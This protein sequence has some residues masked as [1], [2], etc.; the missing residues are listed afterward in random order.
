M[1][2]IVVVRMVGAT[3][4][5]KTNKN[6]IIFCFCFWICAFFRVQLEDPHS[7][8][9]RIKLKANSIELPAN[10]GSSKDTDIP[11][12]PV[13]ERSATPID[14]KPQENCYFC[15][16]GKL[17]T[18]NERGELV[19]ESGSVPAEPEN[20]KSV[21]C[22]SVCHLIKPKAHKW[23]KW[24]MW[25][26]SDE[27]NLSICCPFFP[28]EIICEEIPKHSGIAQ[29]CQFRFWVTEH[30]TKEKIEFIVCQ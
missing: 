10:C 29:W 20:A 30:F 28:T 14:W 21:S 24:K 1:I 26:L 18:V 19:A 12:D 8:E 9:H 2:Y 4:T 16:D 6:N 7:I 13:E 25:P 22:F 11:E 3:L 5:L 23:N 15:V 17:F 27:K